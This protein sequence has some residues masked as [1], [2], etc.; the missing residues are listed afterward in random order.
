MFEISNTALRFAAV[1]EI[2]NTALRF[3]AVFE[4]SNTALHITFPSHDIPFTGKHEPNRIDL[5]STV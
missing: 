3:A 2:S 4:I 5:L 1:F